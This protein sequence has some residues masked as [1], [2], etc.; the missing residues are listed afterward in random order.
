MNII[1]SIAHAIHNRD[2]HELSRIAD[3]L[4][5]LLIPDEDRE[6][7]QTIVLS[8]LELIGELEVA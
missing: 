7:F 6:A 2:E 3:R 5:D 4:N 1:H 8:T